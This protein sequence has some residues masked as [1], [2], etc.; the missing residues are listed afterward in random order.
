MSEKTVVAQNSHSQIL[1]NKK[2]LREQ[3]LNV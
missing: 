1:G 3:G 2:A